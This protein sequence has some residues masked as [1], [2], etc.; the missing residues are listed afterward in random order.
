L[1]DAGTCSV[2]RG[3]GQR[4]GGETRGRD[5][6]RRERRER[7]IRGVVCQCLVCA[8]LLSFAAC[9]FGFGAGGAGCRKPWALVMHACGMAWTVGVVGDGREV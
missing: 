4:F 6:R 1:E 2:V 9:G 7:E 8:H 5:R 3:A